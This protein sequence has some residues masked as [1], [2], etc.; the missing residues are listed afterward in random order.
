MLNRLFQARDFC[1]NLVKPPLYIIESIRSGRMLLACFF[2]SG[3]EV[4]LLSDSC[5][6]GGILFGDS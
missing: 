4:S 2:D 6:Q 5:L 1:A 3:L